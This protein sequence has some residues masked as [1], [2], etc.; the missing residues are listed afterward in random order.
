[1]SIVLL[2]DSFSFPEGNSATNRIYTY[3]AGFIENGI[4]AYVISIRNDYIPNGNGVINRIQY[5]NPI[6]QAERNSSFFLRNWYKFAKY[7]NTI[8]LI[9][10]IN[11]QDKISAIIIDTYDFS[12][13]FFSY[14]L[15]RM[16]GAKLLIEKCE[17]PLRLHRKNALKKMQGHIKLWFE[18]RLCDGLLCI[19]RFLYSYYLDY[20]LS[21]AK[22]IM[23][24]STVDPKKFSDVGDKPVPYKYIGYF[25]GLTFERD[26]V[27][28]LIKAYAPLSKKYP[29]YHL[30]IGGMGSDKERE[31]ITNLFQELNISSQAVLLEYLPRSEVAAY[32]AYADVLV[33]VRAIDFET[34]ASFPSKVVEYMVTSKPVISVNIAEVS[35]YLKD[36]VNGLVIEPENLKQLTEKLD[37]VLENY[38]SALEIAKKGKILI[39]TTFNYDFQAKRIIEFIRSLQS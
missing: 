25:G 3:S 12:I 8:S 10:K 16:V 19:S 1:M 26:N 32:I 4:N 15:T 13:H 2:G 28:L 34:Q 5:F 23:V 30:V 11:K 36:G 17:H 35:D 14:C 39:D 33:M 38:D 6:N 29:D 20:G 31:K 24:P 37:W 7:P 9:R 22:L 27:D 18:S 21:P